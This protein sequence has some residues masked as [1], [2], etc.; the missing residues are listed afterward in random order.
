MHFICR[1]F[2]H[3]RSI[4]RARRF[5]DKEWRSSC[6]LCGTPRVRLGPGKWIPVSEFKAG[7][8]PVPPAEYQPR[9]DTTR[10]VSDVS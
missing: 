4:R 8:E 9:Q 7:P 1:L 5:S 2:G 3:Q 10:N 6:R